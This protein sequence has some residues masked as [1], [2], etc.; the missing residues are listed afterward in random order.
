MN[1]KPF[2]DP[3]KTMCPAPVTLS[4]TPRLLAFPEPFLLVASGGQ[5]GR[6]AGR[7]RLS[8]DT[9]AARGAAT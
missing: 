1:N 2:R 9:L 7:G 8:H 6:R 5:A 3:R 4:D